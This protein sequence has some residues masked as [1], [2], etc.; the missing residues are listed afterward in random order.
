[1]ARIFYQQ[2]CDLQKLAGKTVA[3][4]GYGSPGSRTCT[5]PEG[6]PACDVIVG[7]YEG[8]KSL[9]KGRGSRASRL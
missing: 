9:G 1:M 8:S 5:E 4:I 7:L 6:Q 3:I 2:D